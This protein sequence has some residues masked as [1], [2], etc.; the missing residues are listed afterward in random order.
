MEEHVFSVS[1]LVLNLKDLVEEGFRDIFVEGEISNFKLYP[2]GHM[3]FDLKDESS[4]LPAVM[5]KYVNKNLKFVPESGMKVIA[6]GSLSVYEKQGKYQILISTL[7]P[8]GK[9]A[10]YLAFEQLKEKLKKEGLFDES[11]KKPIPDFPKRIGV[12]TSLAGAAIRD[13]LN[14]IERRFA[15][16]E[17]LINPVQVQ[18]EGSKE[19]IASAIENFNNLEPNMKPDVLIV[20]RGGGSIEDLWAFNEEIV[21]RAISNSNIPVISAI[22]HETDF[23]ISDF[24]SDLRAPTPSAAAELVVRDKAEIKNRIETLASRIKNVFLSGIEIRNHTL[25]N[26][27]DNLL[28]QHPQN[29]INLH[30]QDLDNYM[31]RLMQVSK[32]LIEMKKENLKMLEGKMFALNP[33]AI[34]E[35]GYSITFLLPS[36]TVVLD[37]SKVNKGDELEVKVKKGIIHSKVQ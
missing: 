15:G 32:H 25:N 9:G 1:E 16:V 28:I 2:S 30:L 19:Q 26:L 12:V 5:F 6:K 20:G 23:T 3:Y 31:M 27:R 10:L 36:K 4:I 37:A 24:V 14:V 13:I 11:R 21:A 34:L 17:V 18:G 35:R 33:E 7:E 29:A 22:G 8:S